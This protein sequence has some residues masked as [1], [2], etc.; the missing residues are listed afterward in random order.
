LDG[1]RH[2][3][4]GIRYGTDRL[5]KWTRSSIR[6]GRYVTTSGIVKTPFRNAWDITRRRW[7]SS[8]PRL[9][10][11]LVRKDSISSVKFKRSAMKKCLSFGSMNSYF[12]HMELS[13]IPRREKWANAGQERMDTV[14]WTEGRPLGTEATAI[15][16]DQTLTYAIVAAIIAVLAVIGAAYVKRRKSAK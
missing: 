5:R 10:M 13:E 7:M 4:L 9:L 3:E 8:S 12:H 16:G 1:D 11:R 14:W 15:I 2:G 6:V